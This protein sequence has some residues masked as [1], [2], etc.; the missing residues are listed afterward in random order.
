MTIIK[1]RTLTA[2]DLNTINDA[3]LSGRAVA[4]RFDTSA[5]VEEREICN[6]REGWWGCEWDERVTVNGGA[7][8]V[9]TDCS[10]DRPFLRYLSYMAATGADIVIR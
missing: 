8:L 7:A 2:R 4:L 5:G 3:R 6:V 9:S 1:T 10:H